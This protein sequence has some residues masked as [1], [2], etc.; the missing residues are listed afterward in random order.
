MLYLLSYRFTGCAG[1]ID[2]E[3]SVQLFL[4]NVVQDVIKR[5]APVSW[6]GTLEVKSMG[7]NN[8]ESNAKSC[9][10][11]ILPSWAQSG[12]RRTLRQVPSIKA[13]NLGSFLSFNFHAQM[14]PGVSGAIRIHA[15]LTANIWFVSNQPTQHLQ[16]VTR[17]GT[18]CVP[19]SIHQPQ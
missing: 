12:K 18:T 16:S 10:D 4:Y 7:T 8:I 15:A 9:V 19:F 14:I 17:L 6:A 2:S 13:G 1:T 11:E 3:T 5:K